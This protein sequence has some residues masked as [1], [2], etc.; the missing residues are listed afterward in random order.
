ML[1]ALCSMLCDTMRVHIHLVYTP[2][3]VPYVPWVP[4]STL[5]VTPRLEG[6]GTFKTYVTG[7]STWKCPGSLQPQQTCPALGTSLDTLRKKRVKRKRQFRRRVDKDFGMASTLTCAATA[8]RGS[9]Q[10]WWSPPDSVRSAT[11]IFC[12]G[13]RKKVYSGSIDFGNMVLR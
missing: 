8:C 7:Q 5:Y 12:P 10:L 9:S 11:G 3:L 2:W 13:D 6:H 4:T 1:L